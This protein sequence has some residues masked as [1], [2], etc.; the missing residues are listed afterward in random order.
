MVSSARALRPVLALSAVALAVQACAFVGSTALSN[1]RSTYNAVINQTENEQILSMIVSRRYDET[2]GM[3]AVA[4]VTANLRISA[5][6]GANVGIG[7]DSSYAGN[8][9]P[10]SAGV[11]YE[12]NPTIS[13]V[14]LRGEQFLQRMLAPVSAN[15]MLLL[16]R[17]STPEV[18]TLRFLVRRANSLVN[19]V[20]SSRPVTEGFDRFIDLYAELREAGSLD[21]VQSGEANFEILLHDYADGGSR[22]VEE[23]LRMLGVRG[24]TKSGA[25]VRVPLRFLVGAP[26]TDS[27][28]LET[29]SALEVIEAA[30]EGV[31]VPDSH[32]SDGLAR[33]VAAAPRKLIAI[34]S[35][36]GEPHDA[37]VAVKL[38]GWWFFVDGHD[39]PSKQAFMILRTLIG[40]RLDE[41]TPGAGVPVLTVP[42]AR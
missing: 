14:P 15:Q 32:L 42:A 12:E 34:R 22:G 5:T 11:A 1:G 21:V 24:D 23:L 41:G 20:Y 2:F 25:A 3:L 27:L 36:E 39:A 31:A 13:Y 18:E 10:L 16:S 17:M 9:V 7:S 38:K 19:P 37:L 4:S 29:P 8:L 35:S 30:A 40:M 33:P 28:D 6:V 26:R